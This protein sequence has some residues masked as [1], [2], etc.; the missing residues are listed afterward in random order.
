MSESLSP[1]AR[2]IDPLTLSPRSNSSLAADFTV[3]SSG[4]AALPDAAISSR[5][6][7]RQAVRRNAVTE[8]FRATVTLPFSG[9]TAPP[10]RGTFRPPRET[11][12]SFSA[13]P[14]PPPPSAGRRLCRSGNGR[15]LALGPKPRGAR[16][17]WGGGGAS[18]QHTRAPLPP[19]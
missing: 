5:P 13:P 4:S 1:A 12:R 9:G 8:I 7:A 16:G 6:A 19:T 11:T 2:L 18:G 15:R 17:G 10:R 3:I 14:P